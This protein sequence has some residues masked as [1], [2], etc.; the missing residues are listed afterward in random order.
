MRRSTFFVLGTL[1]FVLFGGCRHPNSQFVEMELRSRE[2]QLRETQE[3]LQRTKS[4]NA[5]LLQELQSVKGS[6][7]A[8]PAAR[9]LPPVKDIVI[10]RQT[11][12]VDDDPVPGDEAL[13]I[14]VEPRDRGGRA[15]KAAGSLE[16]T[17]FEIGAQGERTALSTWDIPN[18]QLRLMW[19]SGLLS[20]GYFVIVPWKN[21]PATN[22]LI[23]LAKF[24]AADGATFEASK[25]VTIR[26]SKNAPRRAPTLPPPEAEP[27]LPQP[28]RV[29]LPLEGP[30]IRNKPVQP[31]APTS[32]QR[33]GERPPV[34]ILLPPEPM[35]EPRR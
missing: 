1:S 3:E 6:T 26:L 7:P 17:A 18:D 24:M 35:G 8:M 10:G 28:R 31:F 22:K 23:V 5:A 33:P 34:A 9:P 21:W 4:F 29:E 2:N 25:D 20:T 12:G 15:V 30:E 19:K 32:W 14:V 11:T 27:T 16:L 13:Q